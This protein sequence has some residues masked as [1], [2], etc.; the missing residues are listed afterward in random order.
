MGFDEFSNGVEFF[1][2]K[3]AILAET[4]R[5]QPKFAKQ[6]IPLHMNVFRL[7]AIEAVKEEAIG[8]GN[9][10]YGW[11][12]LPA[13]LKLPGDLPVRHSAPNLLNYSAFGGLDHRCAAGKV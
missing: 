6:F 2:R 9:A 12:V 10:L 13:K 8:T 3:A 11:H 7:A 1:R 4:N 5:F